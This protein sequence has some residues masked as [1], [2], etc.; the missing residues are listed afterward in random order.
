M[1]KAGAKEVHVRISSPPV[2]KTCY[3]GM[4]TPNEENLIAA[5]LS[6][7][8]ITKIIGADSLAFVSLQGLLNA[9]GE[10]N[11]FCKGCFTGE[12]PIERIK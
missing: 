11:G 9:A 8:E 4:D 10:N 6:I 3:L 7:E 5:N 1:L 2:I 12:Y